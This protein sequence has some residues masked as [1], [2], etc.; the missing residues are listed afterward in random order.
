MLCIACRRLER[1]KIMLSEEALNSFAHHFKLQRLMQV[2]STMPIKWRRRCAVEDV[3]FV[4]PAAAIAPGIEGVGNNLHFPDS[5]VVGCERVERA[6]N[7][8]R[9]IDFR[10][11]EI[12]HLSERMNAGVGP[13]G[14]GYTG[15]RFEKG[16]N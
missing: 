14:T 13:S 11:E 4:Q 12:G 6:A 9:V 2:P 8:V 15:G 3:I 10:R 1:R 16:R 7:S 5:N